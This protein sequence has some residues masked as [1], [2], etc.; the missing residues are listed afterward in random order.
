[1]AAGQKSV[2]ARCGRELGQF[3]LNVPRSTSCPLSL[4]CTPLFN[5]EPKASASPMAQS[6]KPSSS[7]WE[8]PFRTRRRPN[9]KY[10][11]Q[12]RQTKQYTNA[13]ASPMA[14]SAKPFPSIW[15]RPFR[16]RRRPNMKYITQRQQTNSARTLAP[17][18]CPVGQALPQHLRAA[19]ED[20]PKT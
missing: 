9:M 7:I 6:A 11:T 16:T 15:E 18:P 19:F 3:Y 13:S 1:M 4:T 12:R 17:L 20:A 10:I 8:R 14:Q 5:R 2:F